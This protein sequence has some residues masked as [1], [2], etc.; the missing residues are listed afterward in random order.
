MDSTLLQIT[1]DS[2]IA[3]WLLEQAGLVTVMGVVIYWLAKRYEKAE[4]DKSDLAKE[5]IKL[6][7]AYETKLDSDK[8]KDNEIKA[9][10]TEIRDTVKAWQK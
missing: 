4:Q 9:L 5:V 1:A 6:T 10:L 8:E 2:T 3:N 7:V